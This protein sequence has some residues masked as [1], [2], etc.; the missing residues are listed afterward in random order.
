MSSFAALY[1]VQQVKRDSLKLLKGRVALIE[2][3]C[4]A[5]EKALAEMARKVTVIIRTSA[6]EVCR[7][8][9]RRASTRGNREKRPR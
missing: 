8:R 1:L 4:S 6:A 9:W 5:Q 7:V 3:L 2:A